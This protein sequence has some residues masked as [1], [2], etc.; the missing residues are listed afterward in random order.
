LRVKVSL[1]VRFVGIGA[2]AAV[3]IAGCGSNSNGSTS[4]G[5]SGTNAAGCASGSI[6]GQGS[7]FQ[8][9]M[10]QQWSSD[11][12]NQCSG[13]QVTYTGVGSGAGIEQFGLGKADFAGSDVVMISD[14]QGAADKAC[15]SPAIHVPITAGGVAIIYNLNGVDNL[16]LSAPTLA[17]IFTGK[18]KTWN[19]PAIKQDNPGASL[20]S[21]AIAVYHREDDSGTTA[22]FTGFLDAV[23]HSDWPNGAGKESTRI[24][25]GQKATGSDGVTAGVKQTAGGITYAEVSYATQNN[26]PTAKVKGV[27]D[28][29]ALTGD[30]V[31]Q[32]LASGF[33]ITGSGDNLAGALDF[34]NMTS[35]YPISTVS[36]VIVCSKYSDASKGSLVKDYFDYALGGGQSSADQL[37][38]APLPSDLLTKAKA[39]IDTVK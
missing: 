13:A 4:S 31:S 14:E 27:G 24:T 35:G 30:S 39:A 18:I 29:T 9:A 11:F 32:A 38:F 17:K 26:L 23:A 15:G 12:A 10:E 21:Q 34:K 5:G 22:V 16:Q 1:A 20:P 33:S 3:G 19:D 7:T 28:Y 36:Y 8:Q 37:G 25:V 2:V 6:S